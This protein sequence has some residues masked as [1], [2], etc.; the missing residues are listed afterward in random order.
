MKILGDFNSSHNHHSQQWEGKGIKRALLHDNIIV[1]LH[2][3]SPKFKKTLENGFRYEGVCHRQQRKKIFQNGLRFWLPLV[4]VV[5]IS[6]NKWSAIFY[7]S[8]QRIFF[9][10]ALLLTSGNVTTQTVM[11]RAPNNMSIENPIVW[12]KWFLIVNYCT[13][14]TFLILHEF[15]QAIILKM[16]KRHKCFGQH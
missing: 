3:T 16:L 5:L 15:F 9:W 6:P 4:H 14:E 12:T 7:S 2:D 10:K 11:Q 8:P 13:L 1:M